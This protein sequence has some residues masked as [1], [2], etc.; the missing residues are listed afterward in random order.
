MIFI[1]THAIRLRRLK[2]RK[3]AIFHTDPSSQVFFFFAR[4]YY[5]D[6]LRLGLHRVFFCIIPSTTP[7]PCPLGHFYCP[8]YWTERETSQPKKKRVETDRR[9]LHKTRFF[10]IFRR[11]K[12][13]PK[14]VEKKRVTNE[15][16]CKIGT[17]KY[18]RVV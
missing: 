13:Q 6:V 8:A 11:L 18:N 9:N 2:V 16:C 5:L 15:E 7:F 3:T 14:R 4:F 10:F 1:W 17:Q 12:K